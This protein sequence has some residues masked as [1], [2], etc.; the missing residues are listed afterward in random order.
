[1]RP[2]VLTRVA[3][4][5]CLGRGVQA[6]RDALLEQRGGLRPCDL[7]DADLATWIGLVDGLEEDPIEGP[8]A[9]FDCRTH[10]LARL[11]LE[12]D[13]FATAIA[14][15]C[16][17]YGAERIG[18]FVGSSTSGID[19]TEHAYRERGPAGVELPDWFAYRYTHNAFAP[20][21]FVR[22][23]LGLE[24]VTVAI[25]TACSSSAKAFGSAHRAM[26]AGLCDAAVVGGVDSLCLTTL[27]GFN[28]LGLLAPEPCRPWDRHRRGISIGEAAGFALLESPRERGGVALVGYGE[29]SD[30]YHMSAPQPDGAGAATAIRAALER[31]GLQPDAIDYVN[32]HGTGTPANDR[33]EDRAVISALGHFPPCSST[34]GA[35]GHTLGAAGIVEALVS[36]LALEDGFLPGTLNTAEVDPELSA[37][38]VLATE[39]ATPQ[40]ALSNS[41]GFGGSNCSLLLERPR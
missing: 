33:T 5:T 32:L 16:D 9:A 40:V 28:A 6:H 37:R 13:D 27:Y 23:Y 18:V 31:A 26:T 19:R 36:W 7:E 17:R 2:L 24:G 35:T 14:E 12:A 34:K 39:R 30:G 25:A 11:G 4:V 8:L 15:A 1:L 41:F 10:R 38:L 20:A 3:L 29:S 22:R 21:D